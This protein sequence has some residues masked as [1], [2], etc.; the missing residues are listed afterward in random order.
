[1]Q[2]VSYTYFLLQVNVVAAINTDHEDMIVSLI[3]NFTINT[4]Y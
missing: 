2:R 4:M 3:V 1:M